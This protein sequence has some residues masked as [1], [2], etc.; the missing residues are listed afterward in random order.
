MERHTTSP[1]TCFGISRNLIENNDYKGIKAYKIVFNYENFQ[2]RFDPIKS[3]FVYYPNSYI[4]I[5]YK[6][7]MIDHTGNILLSANIPYY[8][9]DGATNDLRANLIFPFVCFSSQYQQNKCPFSRSYPNEGVL[10]KYLP[11]KNL[12]LDLRQDEKWERMRSPPG[13]NIGGNYIPTHDEFQQYLAEAKARDEAEDAEYR[14]RIPSMAVGLHSV[15]PRIENLIDFVLCILFSDRLE[16]SIIINDL[17]SFRPFKAS[18]KHWNYNSNIIQIQNN[19]QE[20]YDKDQLRKKILEYLLK[21]KKSLL[22][23]IDIN[24]LNIVPCYVIIENINI[25]DFN[26]IFGPCGNRNVQENYRK[27]IEISKSFLGSFANGLPPGNLFNRI[28]IPNSFREYN[29]E[30]RLRETFQAYCSDVD[31]KPTGKPSTLGWPYESSPPP[32]RRR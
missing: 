30:N 32:P 4:I 22:Q 24:I 25:Y 15:L 12:K 10:L 7:Q 9:S 27:Y 13:H 11:G 1:N 23:L 29:L 16:S 19:N 26:A 5:V 28:L 8:I 2:Y 14:A 17:P 20:N 3:M 6:L 31:V 18:E 21:Y